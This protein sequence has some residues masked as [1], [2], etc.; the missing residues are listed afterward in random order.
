MSYMYVMRIDTCHIHFK[1]FVISSVIFTALR[2][3]VTGN[4]TLAA[5]FPRQV[6]ICPTV[7]LGAG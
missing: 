5:R 1:R 6:R 7:R 3:R 4:A 2:N